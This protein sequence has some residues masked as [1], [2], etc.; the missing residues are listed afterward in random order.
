MN[1]R[2]LGFAV[3]ALILAGC[4]DDPV[5]TPGSTASPG[6]GET[7]IRIIDFAF[8]PSALS[9]EPGTVVDFVHEGEATHTVTINGENE[10]GEMTAGQQFGFQF[11][12]VGEHRINCD[13]H[14]AE[15]Q[16]VVNVSSIN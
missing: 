11:D 14:P 8:E 10:S 2:F 7:Y 9:L 5:L 13:F 16:L 3:F 4:N 12:R 15:M 6:A 1:I